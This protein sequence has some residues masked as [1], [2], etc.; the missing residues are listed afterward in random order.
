MTVVRYEEGGFEFEFTPDGSSYRGMLVVRTPGFE[1]T[2]AAEVALSKPRSCNEYAARAAE[3]CGMSKQGLKVA[4]NALCTRRYAEVAAEEAEREEPDDLEEEPQ[5]GEEEIAERI[6]RPGVLGRLVE[7]AALYSRVVGER[8]FIGLVFLVALSAQLA[9]LPNGKPLVASAII[10]A[11]PGR[12][13]NF[14]ADCVARLLPPG[15]FVPLESASAKALFYAAGEDASFLRHKWL[16]ANEAEAVDLLVEVLRPLLSGGSARHVTV[17]KDALGRN[18]SQ[19]FVVEG[20]VSVAIPTVRNKLDGQLQSRMLL[21]DLGDYEGRVAAHSAAVSEQLSA[22]YLGTDYSGEIRAWRAA[23]QAL[24]EVRRVV[25]P[26]EDRRF[27]FDSD[28]VPHGARLWTNLLA[29]MCTHGWLEQRNR[30]ERLLPNGERAVVAT[31]EDYEAAY[32]IFEAACERSVVNLSETHRKILDAA[33]RR[34]EKLKARREWDPRDGLTQRE[35]AHEAK[36]SQSTVSGNKTFLVKSVK[37]LRETDGGGLALVKDAEPA[38]WD[39]GDAL[40]GFPKPEQVREWWGDEALRPEPET[41]DRADMVYE[42]ARRAGGKADEEDRGGTDHGGECD[43]R[44]EGAPAGDGDDRGGGADDSERADRSNAPCEPDGRAPGEAIDE[45]GGSGADE[46]ST[47][48]D[49]NFYW[50]RMPPEAGL[51]RR[52]WA[53]KDLERDAAAPADVPY[54]ESLIDF[55]RREAYGVPRAH[56][57][58]ELVEMLARRDNSFSGLEKGSYP[59]DPEEMREVLA[60]VGHALEGMHPKRAGDESSVCDWLQ[61]HVEYW[62][63][64]DRPGE[65]IWAFFAEE[66]VVSEETAQRKVWFKVMEIEDLKP[67]IDWG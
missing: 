2:Y 17:N 61:I 1:E 39:K 22:G 40:L 6:G 38:W 5:V 14:L 46:G 30:E 50:L 13:K 65:G 51:K 24:T 64:L 23:L 29:L 37:L 47:E 49:R 67:K 35:I 60:K 45:I 25:L 34:Q 9:P 62:E 42:G 55:L 12:G 28:E 66:E 36:V 59:T 26:V 7:D 18:T 44:R 33:H 57:A 27:R 16:Y 4:L 63:K 43:D 32:G 8:R 21:S 10:T 15:F 54:G 31:A 53:R 11:P 41:A 19:D 48:D 3:L 52:G 20:P 56:T 58:D